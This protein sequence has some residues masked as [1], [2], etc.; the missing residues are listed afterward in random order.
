MQQEQLALR[1]FFVRFP[2]DLTRAVRNLRMRREDARKNAHFHQFFY[3][4][5]AD[6]TIDAI[7]A[8]CYMTAATAATR[9]ELEVKERA[10]RCPGS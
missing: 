3:R 9:T 4:V 8:F 2:S 10:H 1:D 6:K 5:N 7:C